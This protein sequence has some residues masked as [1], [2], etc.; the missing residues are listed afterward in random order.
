MYKVSTREI[1]L[2]DH[3]STHEAK[4]HVVLLDDKLKAK[5]LEQMCDH[6]VDTSR[7]DEKAHGILYS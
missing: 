7:E 1:F 2:E 5:L 4:I 6:G 3:Q